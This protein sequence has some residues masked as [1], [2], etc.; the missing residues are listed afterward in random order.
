MLTSIARFEIRYQLKAPIF[1]ITSLVFFFFAFSL[2][3]SDE[4]QFGWGGYVVRNSPYTIALVCL[5]MGIFAIFLATAFAATVV[6]RDDEAGFGPIVLATPVT[7]F[8]YLLGR[9]AGGFAVTA[10]AFL[11][12]PLGALVGALW[13]G[14]D[15]QTVGPFRAVPYLYAYFVLSLPTLFVLAACIFAFATLTRSMF[16]TYVVALVGLLLYFLT[17]AYVRRAEFGNLAALVDPFGL[18]ALQGALSHWTP[19]DRNTLLVPMAGRLLLNRIIW[20]GIALGALAVTVRVFRR[21]QVPDTKRRTQAAPET[22]PGRVPALAPMSA[23]RADRGAL[24]WGPLATLTRFD[25]KSVLR[26]PAFFVLVGITLVNTIVGLWIAGDDS[27]SITLPVTRLM[28]QTLF[29]QFTT[30][31]LVIAA[32]YAGELVWRDRER[33]VHEILDATPA[34][35]WAFLAP[36]IIAITIVLL[37][38]AVG[39]VGAALLVQLAKGYTTFEL[40]HYAVWYVL[41]WVVNMALFAVLAVFIQTLVPHKFVGLLVVVLFLAAQLTLTKFGFE[42]NLYQYAGTSAVPLS[43]MNGQGNFARHAAWFRAYWTACAAIL[44]VLAYGLWQRG[45]TAPLRSRLKR[46]PARLRGA[47][48]W[49][50]AVAVVLMFTLGGYIQY[51]TSVLNEYR[52]FAAGQ[53]WEAE[54]EKTLLPLEKVPQ[55]RITDVTLN[56]DIYPDEPRVVTRGR[57]VVENK[58]AAPLREVHVSWVR[59]HEARTFLGPWVWGELEMQSLEV[60]GAHL[61]R[62]FP[63]LHYRI[64]TFDHPLEPGQRAEV[65]FQTRRQQ[66]G[67]RN[68]NNETRVVANGTFLDNWQVTPWIGMSRFM[69]LSDRTVRRKY[70]LVSEI[71]PPKLEDES[72][73]ANNYFRHDSDWVTADITVSSGADQTLVAPGHLEESHVVDGRRI[74]HFRTESP[75]QHFFSIQSARYAVREDKWRDVTL[76]VYHHP[77]HSFSVDRMVRAMKASL[78]YYSTNFSPFQFRQLRIVEFPDYMNFAQAFPGTIPFSEAAGFIVD[79]RDSTR[80]DGITYV[81][82]HEVGHQWW[83]HQVIGADMQGQTVLSE[84]LAQYSALMVMERMYGI[85]EIRRFLKSSLDGYLRGRGTDRI[86]EVPLARVENQAHIRY[87]KGGLVMYLLRDRLGEE[88]VNR[89]LRSLLHDYAFKGPPYATSRDL[90]QRLRAE[91][92]PEDQDLITD[93]FEKITL[94]DLKVTAGRASKRPDGK[95]TVAIDVDARKRYADEKGV[96]TEAPLDESLDVGVF[97]SEPGKRGFTAEGILSLERQRVRSGKQTLT[98]VVDR[99]PKFVGLDPYNKYVDRNSDDNV[100]AVAIQ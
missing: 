28:I 14:L 35:D 90:I 2:T 15:P 57:Y 72:G 41:P 26:S 61:T 39:S 55:P 9:F 60:G 96:E 84:T 32:Y 77:P 22:E 91:A 92:R 7:K 42:N 19:S 69:L 17:A 80:V 48:G 46:L 68:T 38:L 53:R 67:F 43:D 23:P 44:T 45:A 20:L 33:R 99:Q 6:L 73:R 52:T 59:G 56:V 97:T 95:W 71:R 81:T 13:P 78:E 12:V 100:K 83:A 75:I 54:Y 30:F 1:W 88:A 65:R 21:E 62:E 64:Y 31:P 27:S 76:S 29:T 66:R 16:A 70:G 74:S 89:A 85:A 51:N 3:N 49:A 4:I 93:L 37:V 5:V 24:G 63:D 94:Y 8:D 47:P 58:T 98:V 11:S 10:L 18:S 36:K 79:A 82:A 87:Q 34:A 50:I 25:V 86:G 40:G